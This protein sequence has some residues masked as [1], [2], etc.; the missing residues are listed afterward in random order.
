[1][2][3]APLWLFDKPFLFC[4]IL[5]WCSSCCSIKAAIIQPSLIFENQAGVEPLIGHH[6]GYVLRAE[7]PRKLPTAVN[8]T[9]VL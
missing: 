3:G 1:M 2:G 5:S 4:I 6:L 7:S 8:Y 9:A